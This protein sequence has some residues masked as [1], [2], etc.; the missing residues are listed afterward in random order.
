MN[1]NLSFIDKKLEV[2]INDKVCVTAKINID[3]FKD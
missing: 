3:L 2:I 1:I